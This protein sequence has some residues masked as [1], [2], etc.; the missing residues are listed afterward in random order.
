MVL[1]MGTIG[2][3]F[4]SEDLEAVCTLLEH[5]LGIAL[6]LRNSYYKGEY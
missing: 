2:I 1:S 6:E 4:H 3:G 5:E